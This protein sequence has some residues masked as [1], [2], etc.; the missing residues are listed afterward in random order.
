MVQLE[1]LVPLHTFT[2][3]VTVVLVE[4]IVKGVTDTGE[5]LLMLADGFALQ[6]M[7]RLGANVPLEQVTDRE[8]P[9][10]AASDAPDCS[11]SPPDV[12]E[13]PQPV[14][15]LMLVTDTEAVGAQLFA[16]QA[17]RLYVTEFNCG[18]TVTA[19]PSPLAF[20]DVPFAALPDTAQL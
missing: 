3:Y 16:T 8:A 17:V 11:A 2:L 9:T 12:A 13:I 5:P 15:A 19:A 14:G 4:P 7:V 1:V 20:A 18:G 6:A 10:P